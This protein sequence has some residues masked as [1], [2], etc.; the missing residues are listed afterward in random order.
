MNTHTRLPDD[1]WASEQ[2]DGF[3]ARQI[4]T[5][6]RNLIRMVGFD[7]AREVIAGIIND[8]AERKSSD[9]A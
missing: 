7:R 9:A 1:A 5:N 4:R 2:H 6:F 3:F 8:E